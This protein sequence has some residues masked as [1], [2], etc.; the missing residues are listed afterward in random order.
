MS[1]A[2][3]P[4]GNASLSP[5]TTLLRLYCRE[6][7]LSRDNLSKD[8][9]QQ[10]LEKTH[11][12]SCNKILSIDLLSHSLL[13]TQ[14]SIEIYHFLDNCFLQLVQKVVIYHERMASL[15]AEHSSKFEKAQK[16]RFDL[17]LIAIADQ[18]PFLRRVSKSA[19]VGSISRWLVSY[20]DLSK[21]AGRNLEL[22]YLIRDEIL[23]S[24]EDATAQSMFAQALQ[25]PLSKDTTTF[26]QSNKTCQD[27]ADKVT[28]NSETTNISRPSGQEL[29]LHLEPPKED[30]NHQV[31]MRWTKERIPD[32]VLEGTIGELIMCLCSQHEDVRR[33]ALDALRKFRNSL[34]VCPSWPFIKNSLMFTFI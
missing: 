28:E 31:L 21:Q 12:L 6:T 9:L 11:I 2:K 22:L 32:V 5:L 14:A 17:L 3:Y 33:Q 16:E 34:K 18:W 15:K 26:F 25:A 27:K 7:P 1:V 13:E 20:F 29:S 30:Q 10:I 8:L 23:Q 4:S 19:V 24:T